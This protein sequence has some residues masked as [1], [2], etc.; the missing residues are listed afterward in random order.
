MS[1]QHRPPVPPCSFPARHDAAAYRVACRSVNRARGLRRL[2]IA[3]L[4]LLGGCQA[5]GQA[6][7][8]ARY[9]ILSQHA[10]GSGAGEVASDE[11]SRLR[12][13]GVDGLLISADVAQDASIGELARAAA[14][15]DLQLVA[16]PTRE[17]QRVVRWGLGD[18][19]AGPT[20]PFAG[21]AIPL[22]YS[23]AAQ[24]RSRSAVLG[25]SRLIRVP[26]VADRGGG[27]AVLATIDL[28]D[29]ATPT[30]S[31]TE[32]L[33]RQYH[34]AL[35]EGR[36]AGVLFE[37]PTSAMQVLVDGT[38][39][40]RASAVQATLGRAR[41]WGPRLF[42]LEAR[43]LVP[44][45]SWPDEGEIVGFTGGGRHYLLVLN[46][47]DS[48]YLRER[49]ALAAEDFPPGHARA[50]EVP[51]SP[52]GLPGE[53]REASQGRIHFEF[54]LRPGEAVLYELFPLADAEQPAEP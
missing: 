46:A 21:A 13:L 37:H 15:A 6:P 23:P 36:A 2:L 31:L 41:A 52:A 5:P 11:L 38:D 45:P 3:T 29:P 54:E 49:Y 14:T 53:V 10:M 42:G 40:A 34:R 9:W 27:P 30:A 35:A 47:A 17:G 8:A 51:T 50:V 32:H 1:N 39:S 28:G 22:G 20:G 16:A 25:D 33:L 43:R 48:R 24:A 7:H 18:I 4:V 12:R 44:P 19:P 26:G